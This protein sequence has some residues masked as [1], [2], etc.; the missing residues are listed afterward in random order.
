MSDVLELTAEL[1]TDVGKGASRRLRRAGQRVPAIIYG[2]EE[3]PQKLTL[4]V[5]Q[6]VKVMEQETFYSQILN[7]VVDGQ[8]TKAVVRDLQRD[9]ASNKVHHVDFQRIDMN[10]V[11]IATVPIHFMNEDICVGVKMSGGSI[12]HNMTDVE[13]SCLPTDLPES[14]EVDMKDVDVGFSIH[15]SGLALPPGVTLTAFAHG[16]D[17]EDHDIQVVSVEV[18]RGAEEL[19][20]EEDVAEAAGDVPTV[21]DEE[22]GDD[23]GGDED[24]S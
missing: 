12:L 16:G 1:R 3:S 8:P 10:K 9:P 20:D 6:L 18:L 17:D 13:I 4:A 21:G 19:E 15:L 22:A 14:I 23:E 5:N 2:G 7:V 24:K 11:M